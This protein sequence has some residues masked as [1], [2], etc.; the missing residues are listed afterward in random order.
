[1]KQLELDRQAAVKSGLRDL[2]HL[3]GSAGDEYYLPPISGWTQMDY[4]EFLQIP[5]RKNRLVVQVGGVE[6][7]YG[8]AVKH[9]NH[10]LLLNSIKRVSQ[11]KRVCGKC[12]LYGHVRSKCRP[13]TVNFGVDKKGEVVK[14][15]RDG[16]A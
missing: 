5:I 1:M 7:L 4:M 14:L 16:G 3:C 8:F 2:R 12:G 11:S 10:K 9:G 6:T 15:R 13:T